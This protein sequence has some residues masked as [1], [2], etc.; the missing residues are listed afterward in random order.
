MAAAGTNVAEQ[1]TDSDLFLGGDE[2][3]HGTLEQHTLSSRPRHIRSAEDGLK[4][5]AA[6]KQERSEGVHDGL[7]ELT[8]ADWEER[9]SAILNNFH[10]G[11]YTYLFSSKS[12]ERIVKIHLA[13][14][15]GGLTRGRG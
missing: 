8:A 2:V 15:G 1:L 13:A 11:L 10:L 7:Y 6:Q 4:G 14:W 5:T 3:A 12:G 9:R